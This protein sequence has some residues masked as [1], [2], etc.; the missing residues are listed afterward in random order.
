MN[1]N[2]YSAVLNSA[3]ASSTPIPLSFKNS[4]TTTTLYP[5]R[6][7]PKLAVRKVESEAKTQMHCNQK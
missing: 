4:N 6:Q 2:D 7:N 5:N 1:I 3:S